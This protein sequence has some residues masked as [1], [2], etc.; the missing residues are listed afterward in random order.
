MQNHSLVDIFKGNKQITNPQEKFQF[1]KKRYFLVDN[2]VNRTIINEETLV[3]E[4]KPVAYLE[5]FF[6]ILYDVHC[7][8]RM[9]QGIQKTFDQIQIRYHGITRAIVTYFRQTCY[10]CDL[11]KN[12]ES[13]PRLKPIVS[14]E[15]LERVQIDLI[16]MRCQPDGEFNWIAHN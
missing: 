9:H 6:D 12:Q 7:V 16:D 10:I 5:Q 8:K 11:K 3:S 2:V 1:K 15:I 14:N 4:T 13:Q